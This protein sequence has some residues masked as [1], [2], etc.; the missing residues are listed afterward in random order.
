[1][2]AA[3]LFVCLVAASG[4]H[5]QVLPSEPISVGG[6]RL[7]LGGELTATIAP[8]DPGFF[9][10]TDYEYNA[11]RNLRLG[12]TAE[13][14]AHERLQLLTEIRMD[15]GDTFKPYG[16]YARVR[17]WAT[18]RFDIQIGRVPPTFGAFAR[19]G[20]GTG[21]LLIGYPLAYQYLTSLRTDAMPASTADLL[22]MRGRG[23]LASY[24]IGDQ[25]EAPGLPLIN[26]SRWDTG[27]QLHG[28][29]GMLEWTGSVTTGSLSNPRVDDDNGGRQFAGRAVLRPAPAFAIGLSGARGAFMNRSLQANLSPGADIDDAVQR[30]VGIDAEY[31]AG[32]LIARGE[33]VWSRWNLPAPF[34]GGPLDATAVM[35]EGRYRVAP[36]VHVAARAEHLGFNTIDSL[37]GPEAWEAPVT[38]FELGAGWALQRNLMAKVSWQ[39]NVRDGGRIRHDSMA[40]AQ[41]LYWF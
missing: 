25:G 13:L 3:V 26:L 37:Q 22:R 10:Y 6:G 5:A 15:R 27:V 29:Y 19:S 30:A 23:W 12:V 41:L 11:L 38:R 33:V 32:Y 17:P 40:A 16:V 21:N 14:R 9:N 28:V 8:D 34:S 39:R 2:R 24:P 4:A 7:V 35:V 1:M 18:R 36:G 31:S 20:Y